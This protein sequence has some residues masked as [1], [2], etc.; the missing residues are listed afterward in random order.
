MTSQVIGVFA[1]VVF[2]GVILLFQQAPP[3][4]DSDHYRY[5]SRALV[6]MLCSFVSLSL[7]SF[8]F[9]VV[10]GEELCG[11]AF[12]EGA[13]AGALF[14]IG[15][16]G[17]FL[18][19]CWLFAAHRIGGHTVIWVKLLMVVE[20]LAAWTFIALT[21][22]DAVQAIELTPQNPVTSGLVW[23]GTAPAL[24]PLLIFVAMR[25]LPRLRAAIERRS[26]R[27]FEMATGFSIFC[28][29]LAIAYVTLITIYT[30][31]DTFPIVI[32]VGI[33]GTVAVALSLYF[34]NMMTIRRVEAPAKD[35]LV[36]TRESL[37]H[38]LDLNGR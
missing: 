24:S 22:F 37:L 19:I 8:L 14:G 35:R 18:S 30:S 17:M 11:R 2:T 13:A 3:S 9:S 6:T 7:A 10:S 29:V 34:V 32:R 1:A 21:V 28:I 31:R 36:R 33:T 16:T 38:L 23:W 15:A 4:E 26:A 27:M 25:R 20:M 5:S 12:A